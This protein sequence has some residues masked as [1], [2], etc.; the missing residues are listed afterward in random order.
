MRKKGSLVKEA[1]EKCMIPRSLAYKLLNQHNHSNRSLIPG[2]VFTERKKTFK[3][4]FN[5]STFS[6]YLVSTLHEPLC[7][8]Y[9]SIL[10]M[11][12]ALIVIDECLDLKRKRKSIVN[13]MIAK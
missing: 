11:Y 6:K 1:K 7:V 5:F 9:N 4:C 13:F 3:N 2:S 8:N 12:C 10:A